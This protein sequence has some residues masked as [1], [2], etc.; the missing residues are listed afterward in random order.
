MS[1]SNDDKGDYVEN[2]LDLDGYDHLAIVPGSGAT[3]LK[4]NLASC[5]FFS[6]HGRDLSRPNFTD[7]FSLSVLLDTPSSS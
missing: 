4:E 5:F 3:A 2:V 1:L 7:T 6:I